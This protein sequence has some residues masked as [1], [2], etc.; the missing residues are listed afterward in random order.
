MMDHLPVTTSVN[1]TEVNAGSSTWKAAG[2]VTI[3]AAVTLV[4]R[5]YA[6][7]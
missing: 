1:L 2:T 4:G 3:K 6:A 5:V 7:S